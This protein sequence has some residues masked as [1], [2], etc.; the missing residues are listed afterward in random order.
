MLGTVSLT[1]RRASSLPPQ[2]LDSSAA[3]LNTTPT[4]LLPDP[5]VRLCSLTTESSAAWPHCRPTSQMSDA[6][7]K[8]HSL[9]PQADLTARHYSLTPQYDHS[10]PTLLSD[11][12]A[13]RSYSPTPQQPDS[14]PR[15]R[16]RPAPPLHPPNKQQAHRFPPCV[17]LQRS[18]QAHVMRRKRTGVPTLTTTIATADTPVASAPQHRRARMQVPLPSVGTCETRATGSSPWARTP[19][20]TCPP[21]ARTALLPRQAP[22]YR[23]SARVPLPWHQPRDPP[24][25][26]SLPRPAT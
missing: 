4:E 17:T 21:S 12:T 16:S 19:T 11:D 1:T 6:I 3:R 2:L 15:H 9:T 24:L 26:P 5:T 13:G 14:T 22:Q 20:L 18:Q 8:Y 25:P 7:L 10:R 23:P